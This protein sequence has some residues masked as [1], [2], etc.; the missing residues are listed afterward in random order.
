MNVTRYQ[1]TVLD[2]DRETNSMQRRVHCYIGPCYALIDLESEVNYSR[3]C[4]GSYNQRNILGLKSCAPNQNIGMNALLS[5][6]LPFSPPLTHSASKVHDI[7][8]VIST[9]ASV[10]DSTELLCLL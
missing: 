9:I 6:S 5:I 4:I 2:L 7:A 10:V 3:I 1:I 8:L